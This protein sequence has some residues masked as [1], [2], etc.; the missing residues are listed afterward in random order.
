[1]LIHV[2]PCAC[3]CL[4]INLY[5][6]RPICLSVYQPNYLCIYKY[7]CPFG[8]LFNIDF[9][10]LERACPVASNILQPPP[11]PKKKKKKNHKHQTTLY[12]SVFSFPVRPSLQ[13]SQGRVT[14]VIMSPPPQKKKNEKKNNSLFP[15]SLNPFFSLSVSLSISI[16]LSLSL[17]LSLLSLYCSL[18]FS[19]F[20]SLPITIFYSSLFPSLS[21]S[22]LLS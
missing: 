10:H 17:S 7:I 20:F 9:S 12:C 11:P 3:E 22:L 15:L 1:M 2:C 5:I 16:S 18:F 13:T 8:Y 6:N 4:S 21:P 19:H 14:A